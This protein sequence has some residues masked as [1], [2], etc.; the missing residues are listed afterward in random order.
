MSEQHAMSKM[1]RETRYSD[2]SGVEYAVRYDS[3]ANTNEGTGAIEFENCGKVQIPQ[4]KIDWLIYC[5]QQI[6]QEQGL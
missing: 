2:D 5:L 1:A 3:E 4:S 6:K